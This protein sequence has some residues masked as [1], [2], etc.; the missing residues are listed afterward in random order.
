MRL[1]AIIGGGPG[2][3]TL[4]LILQ[5]HGIPSV[6]YERENADTNS[7][8]GGSSDIHEDSGQLA[9]REAGLLEQSRLIARYEGEDFHLFDKD[10]KMY[11]DDGNQ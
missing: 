7:R 5:K 4:W 9:L 2:G 1:I 3:L 11:M 6:I 8:R 10:G